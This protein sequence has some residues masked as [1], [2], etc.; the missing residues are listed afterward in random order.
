MTAQT[1]KKCSKFR[2]VIQQWRNVYRIGAIARTTMN[3]SVVCS[4]DTVSIISMI[5]ASH[6]TLNVS[7]AVMNYIDIRISDNYFGY[8]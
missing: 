8:N 4:F 2:D 7:N 1:S 6:A 3:R 5:V